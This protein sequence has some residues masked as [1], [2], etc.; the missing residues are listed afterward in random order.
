MPGLINQ[1]PTDADFVIHLGDI[2]SSGSPCNNATF[3]EAAEFMAASKVPAFFVVGDNEWNDCDNPDA[4]LALWRS[5]F[6]RFDRKYWD[7]DLGVTTMPGRP[8]S[9]TFINRGTLFIG[10]NLVGSPVVD[11]TEWNNRTTTQWHWVQGLI[12]SRRSGDWPIG[13]IVI[14]YHANLDGKHRRFVDPFIDYVQ[15]VLQNSISIMLIGGDN[16]SWLYEPNYKNQPSLLRVRK[17]GGTTEPALRIVVD[18]AASRLENDFGTKA[19]PGTTFQLTRFPSNSAVLNFGRGE[20]EQ[21]GIA[22]EDL[23]DDYL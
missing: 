12:E 9:F 21:G 4:A 6:V 3:Q 1:I 16:H 20:T 11:W 17:T 18:P 14:F 8:E 19:S 22:S 7:H 5:M 23:D 15:N 13:A 10:L 2:K